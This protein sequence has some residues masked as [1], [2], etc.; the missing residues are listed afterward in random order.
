MRSQYGAV[1]VGVRHVEDFK[2]ANHSRST[3]LVTV[4]HFGSKSVTECFKLKKIFFCSN[5]FCPKNVIFCL[6]MFRPKFGRK[7]ILPKCSALKK[8]RTFLG[9]E[10]IWANICFAEKI[11]AEIIQI[12]TFKN[13]QIQVWFSKSD[14]FMLWI[15]DVYISILSIQCLLKWKTSCHLFASTYHQPITV[16]QLTNH[17][18]STNQS[19]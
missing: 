18:R 19:Q 17:S 3:N 5:F 8:F 14:I 4:Y 9:P 2:A 15:G 16:D 13:Q 6:K 7:I 11:G 1:W 12:A 10:N